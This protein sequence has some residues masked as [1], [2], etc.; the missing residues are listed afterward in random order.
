[1][2]LGVAAGTIAGVFSD[3]ALI[4]LP[5]AALA[6]RIALRRMPA[7][8]R[9]PAAIPRSKTRG[10]RPTVDQ[11]GR[12]D[13]ILDE[14]V[15]RRTATIEGRNRYLSIVNA[16]SFA[17]A[18][19]MDDP[20]VLERA[21]RLVARLLGARSAQAYHLQG[22]GSEAF[23]LV[24]P[25]DAADVHAPQVP[26]SLLERV[27]TSGCPLS[28]TDPESL[29]F[30][31]AVGEAFTVVPLIVGGRRLGAFALCGTGAEWSEAE[32]HLL[33]L[34]GRDFAMALGNAG[35]FRNALAAA[36]H[37]RMV[38]EAIQALTADG[39]GG[40]DTDVALHML[41][42]RTAA[43]EVA[44]LRLD[45][46]SQHLSVEAEASS[47]PPGESWAREGGPA[48]ADLMS[49]RST[50]LVL[51]RAGEGPLPGSLASLG[52]E[53]FVL[54]P[55]VTRPGADAAGEDSGEHREQEIAGLL[56]AVSRAG[57]GWD[58]LVV[59]C[60]VR[61]GLALACQLETEE[62]QALQRQRIRELAGLAE[63]AR[64]MQSSADTERLQLGFAQTLA[65]LVSYRQMYIAR[66]DELGVLLPVSVFGDRGKA[67]AAREPEAIDG[68]HTW[69]GLRAPQ[70]WVHGDARPG[71]VDVPVRGGLAVP[72]R[73]K[74]Q[75]LGVVVIELLENLDDEQ[76][77]IV[78][79]AVEQ[80]SLAL[81]GAALYQQATER[82]QHIQALSNLARVVASV[83]S[84]REA[85]AA[86]AE[87][88]RWLIPF[89]RAC[90]LLLD[91]GGRMVEPY[92]TYP[93]QETAAEATWLE[94]SIISVPV[95]TGAAVAIRRDDPRYAD[96]DWS[97]LGTDAVE[98]AAVPV[99][100]GTRTAA[101]FVLVNSGVAGYR[102][103]ELEALEEVAGL[104]G[105][106]I[107][108]LRLYEQ[109]AYGARHDLLTGLPNYRYLQERLEQDVAGFNG[110]G[111]STLLV[112]DMDSLKAFNDTLGHGAGD[113]L[114]RIVARELRA[115]CRG[116][117]F[118]ARTGGDEFVLLLEGAGIEAAEQVAERVHMALAEAH[119]EIEGSPT[120]VAVSIGI[121][122]A[123]M[124]GTSADEVLHAG[125]QAMYQAK[126]AGGAR[127]CI[128]EVEGGPT[129]E[130][131]P[132][133]VRARGG[134]LVE[135][136]ARALL[137]GATAEE[138]SAAGLAQHWVIAAGTRMG[139]RPGLLTQV[140]MLVPL[141]CIDR[142]ETPQGH[143][144]SRLATHF[145]E[146]LRGEWDAVESG[147]FWVRTLIPAAIAAAW[148]HRFL[149]ASLD[150]LA[151]RMEALADEGEAA[152]GSWRALA[153]A[154]R[155]GADGRREEGQAA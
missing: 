154:I 50:A 46:A 106:T 93:E 150:G 11:A 123:P 115:A 122:G 29:E 137:S 134:R 1:M 87:E 148:E 142:I 55:V 20:S 131:S 104:L 152:G 136:V 7:V 128:A 76:V 84:L 110:A 47:Q 14:E 22:D 80:L 99:R 34:I 130:R 9:D 42:E 91:D 36:Q 107:E 141:A 56:V 103:A 111:E 65:T 105:V 143:S 63:V 71:F 101:V 125:D 15:G 77:R 67:L 25:V 109:A 39:T 10:A 24:V 32:L 59:D 95:E 26:E 118:V 108:R 13:Q 127:T 19:P 83:V 120:R 61:F 28:S 78:E 86:F 132:V 51:G 17:L 60:F 35:L 146:Q 100:Q 54:L 58:A 27:A 138:R 126:F 92:A 90:M 75:A 139:Q 97:V 31:A 45:R 121:A 69:F 129:E 8:R 18:A 74:G 33:L 49:G 52:A 79:R 82:A 119:L 153:E 30:R 133:D 53:T 38:A 124:H 72:M 155:D 4:S 94:P 62:L 57:T 5:L 116:H 21:A 96:L 85:F 145:V 48:V 98:V 2:P 16:V 23:H 70:R 112:V 40:G 68:S 43:A 89:D 147:R 6:F 37:E 44:F 41:M 140:R 113:R 64:T 102:E 151:A 66:L 114:I 73:P 135:S 81:D 3:I 149:G 12:W 88:V 144:D 117:D